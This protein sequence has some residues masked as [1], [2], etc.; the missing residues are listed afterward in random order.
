MKIGGLTSAAAI[1]VSGALGVAAGCGLWAIALSALTCFLV[2]W[3][4]KK[5]E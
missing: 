3:S 1:W 4:V 2:L 5:W